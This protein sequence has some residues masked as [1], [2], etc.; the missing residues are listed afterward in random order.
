[1]VLGVVSDKFG[2]KRTTA[3]YIACA[4]ILQI[5]FIIVDDPI[6]SAVLIGLVGFFF[7]PLFPA[8]IIRLSELLPPALGVR[9]VSFVASIGQL[10]GA[11]LPFGLGALSHLIGLGVFGAV[12]IAQ[13]AGCLALWMAFPQ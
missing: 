8:A 6:L 9:A 5:L 7:G 4:L 12:I 3:V 2:V 11:L 1:M 13:L 10:G